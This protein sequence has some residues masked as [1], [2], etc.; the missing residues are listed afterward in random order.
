MKTARAAIKTK[1]FHA[2]IELCTEVIA[3]EP[4]NGDAYLTRGIALEWLDKSA[5]AAADFDKGLNLTTPQSAVF[6]EQAA[7]A[8]N[9]THQTQK[10]LKILDDGIRTHPA[11]ILFRNKG[12]ILWQLGKQAESLECFEKAIK[13]DP[14]EYWIYADRA[15]CYVQMKNWKSALAD[16]NTMAKLRPTEPRTYAQ[17]ARVYEIIGERKNAAKDR[18]KAKE[19]SKD[20]WFEP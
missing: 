19:L 3:K 7:N 4:R 15:N 5:A 1:N 2:V 17:R 12:Q 14:K 8:Y 13:F 6:F 11:S 18:A 9:D 16:L 20:A 10:A